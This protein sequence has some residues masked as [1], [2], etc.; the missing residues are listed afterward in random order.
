[1][2]VNELWAKE[3]KFF[4]EFERVSLPRGGLNL[5]DC[6]E[7]YHKVSKHLA[8]RKDTEPIRIADVGCW[9]GLSSTVLALATGERPAFIYSI[10]WFQGS[11]YTN[12][13]FAGSC[14]D[15]KRIFEKNIKQFDFSNK[16]NPMN[17]TSLEAVNSF[18]DN[19][20][21]VVFIDADHRYE[22]VVKDIKF[23]LPKVR[24]GGLLMGHDCEVILSEGVN[25]LLH[26][27][28]NKDM[29]EVLHLG[30]CKAVTDLGGDKVK[31]LKR[32]T[33]EESLKSSVWYYDKS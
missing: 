28:K 2:D 12:L 16:I 20:L 22:E 3:D 4:N 5:E 33:P 9:T 8:S 23:W 17:L 32:F 26:V 10:D 25:S 19:A 6:N 30:V 24:P 11:P 14:F 18:A 27:Y 7:L 21:D 15:I 31:S 29:I 1:M 13:E